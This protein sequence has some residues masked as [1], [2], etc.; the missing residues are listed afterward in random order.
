MGKIDEIKEHI[1]ALKT[2]LRLSL[3]LFWLAEPEL[4]SYTTM[5]K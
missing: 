5:V 1:G 2:Y 4:P 3:P